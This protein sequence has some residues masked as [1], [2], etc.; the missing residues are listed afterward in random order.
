[1][2]KFSVLPDRATSSRSIIRDD[3]LGV[4]R[5]APWG[6]LWPDRATRTTAPAETSLSSI[7]SKF[8]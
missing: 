2:Q 8:P 3:F 1:L 5:I 7:W 4:G 6:F